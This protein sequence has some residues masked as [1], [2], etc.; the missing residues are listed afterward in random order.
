MESDRDDLS[1]YGE[2]GADLVASPEPSSNAKNDASWWMR[3]PNN[4]VQGSLNTGYEQIKQ[5]N[6]DASIK[7][8]LS[9]LNVI[10][11]EQNQE[12]DS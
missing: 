9:D 1:G 10:A 4:R 2:E 8:Q 12:G 5:R 11:D 6:L 7:K 3:K